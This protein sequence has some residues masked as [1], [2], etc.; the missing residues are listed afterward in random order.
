MNSGTEEGFKNDE[1]LFYGSTHEK[2]NYP[3]TGKDPSPYTGERA[4]NPIFR[5]I[6]NRQIK[7]G[8]NS[9]ADFRIA[10]TQ[11][12]GEMKYFEPDLVIISAGF[13]AHDEYPLAS[14]EL[15]ENDFYWA[16]RLVMKACRKINPVSPVPVVSILE[17]GYDL[18]ALASSA[19]VHVN[20]LAEGYPELPVRKPG[21]EVAALTEHLE[22]IGLV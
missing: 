8:E 9:A 12:I 6:V 14:L 22:K 2:D 7:R 13:D 11:V 10:W 1:T 20:A 3:G 4:K 15:Q 21:D 17:G 5:R 18:N 16:T 19:L